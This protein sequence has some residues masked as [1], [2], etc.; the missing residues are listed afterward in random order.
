MRKNRKQRN[1]M[2]ISLVA[3]LVCMAVGY[4]AFS[5]NL[6][7]SGTSNITSSF[8]VKITDITSGSI[9]GNAQDLDTPRHTDTTANFRAGLTSPGDS[10]TYDI[11]I[12]N[13]GT[14]DATIKLLNYTATQSDVIK[15]TSSGVREGQVIKKGE[16]KH[17]YITVAF[18][19]NYNGPSVEET[20][21][22]DVDIDYGQATGDEPVVGDNYL[23]TYD[24]KTN[25][26]STED[27][28]QETAMGANI[29][30]SKTAV[31]DGWTFVGWNTDKDAKTGMK[32]YEMPS[33]DITV[34]AIFSKALTATYVMGS[35]V[36]SIGQNNG[37]CTIYNHETS[38]EIT[39]PSITASPTYVADG[40]YNGQ[41]KIGTEG[42]K[43]TITDNVTLTA[44]AV[45][46]QMSVTL[47]STVTTNSI[48]V[49]AN[50]TAT[51]GISKYEYSID[52][53]S[54]WVDGGTE[55]THTFE[56][57][58]QETDYNL[59]VRVT[60]ASGLQQTANGTAKT[61]T[62]PT[63]T[64]TEEGVYP[65]TV[66]AALPEGC[67]STYTCSYVKD[68][69]EPVTVTGTTADVS[70]DNHGSLVVYISDGVTTVSSTYNVK[71]K[72]TASDLSYENTQTQLPCEDAQCALDELKKMLN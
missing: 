34:Y 14:L 40:W 7:I 49:V 42:T 25:G 13:Q 57:L 17:L 30:L 51:S 20:V 48:T 67:G 31:R 43:Y 1:I 65:K 5:A 15:V 37:N 3:V 62:I 12:E 64:F 2:I 66:H 71:I 50:A 33:N 63:A 22:V 4:A 58:T 46:D 28:T 23:V 29:D 70:F 53:G 41:S 61:A 8:D 56:G 69:A 19:E 35:N 11:K 59:M 18:D 68:D 55:N 6:N 9:A 26:G 45:V 72:L 54:H 47:S 60:S 16:E 36:Q 38:C 24:S 10:I 27:Q 44:N 39:L 32:S 52:D 21:D